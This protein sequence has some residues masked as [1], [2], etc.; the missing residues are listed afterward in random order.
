MYYDNSPAEEA[1]YAWRCANSD[2]CCSCHIS[3]PCSFCEEGFSLS[4]E[5]YVELYWRDYV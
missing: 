4:E 3:P 2:R 1:R 5:E